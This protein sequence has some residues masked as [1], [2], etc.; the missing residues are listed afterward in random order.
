MHAVVSSLATRS[1]VLAI[2]RLLSQALLMLSPIFLVR[3]LDV[4]EFGRYRQFTVTAGVLTMFGAF[5]ISSSLTYFV[6]K[7]PQLASAYVTNACLLLLGSTTATAL[8]AWICQHFIIPASI[9]E[10]TL[11]LIAYSF[12]FANLDVFTS[13]AL[14]RGRSDLVLAYSLGQI[15]LRLVATVGS[16]AVFHEV[17]PMFAAMLIA[18]ATKT[19]AIYIWL[20]ARKLITF[21]LEWGSS[22]RAAQIHPALWIRDAAEQSQ[23]QHGT[24]SCQRHHGSEKPGDL[25]HCGLQ[26]ADCHYSE[27][28]AVRGDLS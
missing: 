9:S 22:A 3:L 23:R 20:R 7:A 17:G 25:C 4:V 24:P 10:Y 18:E 5:A 26:R 16:A 28:G 12:L 27:V 15:A 19:L 6:A 11:V 21:R 8:V 13:Y 2:A 1:V 14:A